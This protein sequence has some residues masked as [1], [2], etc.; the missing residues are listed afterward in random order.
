MTIFEFIGFILMAC[1]I[2]VFIYLRKEIALAFIIKNAVDS[3]EPVK[4]E[5]LF[6]HNERE[7]ERWRDHV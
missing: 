1:I 4:K 7:I 5:E 2:A 6:A 3:L